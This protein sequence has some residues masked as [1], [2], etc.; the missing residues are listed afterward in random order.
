MNKKYARIANHLAL[1]SMVKHDCINNGSVVKNV[2]KHLFGKRHTIE[3]IA[4]NIGLNCGSAKATVYA[5]YALYQDT[6]KLL[7]HVSKTTGLIGSLRKNIITKMLNT[8]FTMQ[9]TFI[10]T[11]ALQIS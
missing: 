1:N 4:G 11:A 2:P 9:H 5:N 3:S 10:K 8:L 7:S 6:V